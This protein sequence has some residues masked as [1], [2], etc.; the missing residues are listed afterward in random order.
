MAPKSP[1]CLSSLCL[2]LCL[3]IAAAPGVA[4]R[5][6]PRGIVTRPW[7]LFRLVRRQSYFSNCPSTTVRGSAT[8]SEL[9]QHPWPTPRCPGAHQNFPALCS[10]T[11]TCR[12]LPA[13]VGLWVPFLL[14]Y[15]SSPPSAAAARVV[16]SFVSVQLCC[17][18]F[19]H[20]SLTRKCEFLYCKILL[21]GVEV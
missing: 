1:S 13:W 19:I 10:F 8:L 20:M 9:Q 5:G 7:H 4:S 16:S 6:T 12:L 11:W 17:D 21:L 18:K 14:A 2:G 15:V 3:G